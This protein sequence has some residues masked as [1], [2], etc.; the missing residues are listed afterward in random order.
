MFRFQDFFKHL[1]NIEKGHP[2]PAR[3]SAGRGGLLTGPPRGVPEGRLGRPPIK[4]KKKKNI[5][6]TNN[7]YLVG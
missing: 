2:L 5:E 6:K 3:R 7:L 1:K 4:K